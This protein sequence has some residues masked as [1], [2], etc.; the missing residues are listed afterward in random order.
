M[1]YTTS[2]PRVKV[3]AIQA[4]NASIRVHTKGGDVINYDGKKQQTECLT[5]VRKCSTKRKVVQE[6]RDWVP[7]SAFP[8]R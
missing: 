6:N 3:K 8:R 7:P 1:G 2:G 5:R 4:I